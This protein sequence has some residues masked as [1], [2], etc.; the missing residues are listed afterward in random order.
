LNNRRRR[1]RALLEA[2]G[3]KEYGFQ[4][5]SEKRLSE[6]VSTAPTVL[7][8]EGA[9][10]AKE[11]EI[12]FRAGA[13]NGAGAPRGEEQG[14]TKQRLIGRLL[15]EKLV[16]ENQKNAIDVRGRMELLNLTWGGENEI[17]RLIGVGLK[18]DCVA[19]FT[20]RPAEHLVEAQSLRL[21][22]G[23]SKSPSEKSPE[24]HRLKLDVDLGTFQERDKRKAACLG[25]HDGSLQHN[26]DD[27]KPSNPSE[28]GADRRLFAKRRAR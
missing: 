7:S 2:L 12:A 16:C 4:H 17:A 24:A 20:L 3:L 22:Q 10:R 27:A 11:T 15:R 14:R 21:I 13:D 28:P 5:A 25:L 1:R 19:T 26:E 18:I 6:D 23:P 8:L 9:E